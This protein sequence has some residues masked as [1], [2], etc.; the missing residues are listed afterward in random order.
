MK[1]IHIYKNERGVSVL[2]FI[3][4]TA[5]VGAVIFAVGPSIKQAFFGT[6]N[7]PGIGITLVQHQTAGL[8]ESNKN[9]KVLSGCQTI[10][11]ITEEACTKLKNSP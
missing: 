10:N 3:L 1:H 6:P 7:D 11:N 4:I 2:E 8:N 9:V 5:L